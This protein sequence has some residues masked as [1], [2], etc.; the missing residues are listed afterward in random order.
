MIKF[1]VDCKVKQR[2]YCVVATNFIVLSMAAGVQTTNN[3]R[4]GRATAE[5]RLDSMWLS[6]GEAWRTNKW[7]IETTAMR[8]GYP[9]I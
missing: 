2:V 3:L 1:Y 6:E 4:Q 7:T 8:R 9:N 5:R